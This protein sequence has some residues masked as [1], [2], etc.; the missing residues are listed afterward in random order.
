MTKEAWQTK[1]AELVT[2][3]DIQSR[4]NSLQR[5]F[6]DLNNRETGRNGRVTAGQMDK[7][8]DKLNKFRSRQDVLSSRLRKLNGVQ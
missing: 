7:K 5:Q 1:D 8:M 6:D 3:E 2:K 4:I